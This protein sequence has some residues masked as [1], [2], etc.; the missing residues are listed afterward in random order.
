MMQHL[1]GFWEQNAGFGGWWKSVRDRVSYRVSPRQRWVVAGNLI[2]HA[3]VGFI[4]AQR[5]DGT[6]RYT[7]AN[8][9]KGGC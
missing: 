5:K 4:I 1:A 8:R 3:G 9:S 2:I 7:D 6:V